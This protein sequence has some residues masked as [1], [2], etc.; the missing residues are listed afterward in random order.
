M[1]AVL[2]FFGV[3]IPY[4]AVLIFIVG[5]IYRVWKWARSPVP[6]RIPTTCG[7]QKSLPWI[8]ASNLENPSNTVGVIGRMALEVLLFR[9]LL[10]NTTTELKQGVRKLVY[11]DSLL[12]WLGALLFH[13]SLLIILL[14]HSKFFLEPVPSFLLLFERWDGILQVSVP[15]WFPS[16]F[17]IL[18]ISNIV[19]LLALTY[20]L[21]RRVLTSQI[22]Y[23]SLPAD[24]LVVLLILGVVTSGI[25]MKFFFKVDVVGVKALALG[26]IT[27][28]PSVP[29]DG[30]GLFFYIHLFLIC[31]LI[32]Y[33]PFSKL[34]HMPGIF[35][36][37]TRNLANTNRISRHINP[38]DK[39]VK[40]HTYEEWE[41]E[42]RD[43]MKD[44]GLPLEKE[45]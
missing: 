12:L 44:A 15:S 37:P 30:I 35:L 22:R 43:V 8:K 28:Q 2:F 39:P 38:W 1:T 20:L 7:Q 5:I 36:S 21:L 10:R 34:M 26:V 11:K 40:V 24:Y 17:P 32:A 31:A 3:I 27:F 19:I 41:D 9:S 25:L 16:M 45:Q 14:R 42:F 29:A 13:W 23:I 33:F 6:F 4:I 18:F